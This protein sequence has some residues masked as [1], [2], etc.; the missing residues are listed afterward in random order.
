L[1]R[2]L[3][4]LRLRR[5]GIMTRFLRLLGMVAIRR[6]SVRSILCVMFAHIAVLLGTL[7]IR[8]RLRRQRG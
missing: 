5:I 6:S 8:R 2:L 4:L 3:W 1:L 7:T